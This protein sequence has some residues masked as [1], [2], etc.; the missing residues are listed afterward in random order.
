MLAEDGQPADSVSAAQLLQH[1][2]ENREVFA[3]SFVGFRSRLTARLDGTAYRGTCEFR[4]PDSLQ[5]AIP[6]GSVPESVTRTVR[7]MLMHRVPS[8][9]TSV[10]A[11]AYG[12]LD[13]HPLGR[14]IVL[15]DAYRSVYRIRDRRILQVD[16]RLSEFRRVL[17]VLE[18]ETAD[19]GRYLPRHVFA[20]VL[21]NDS[22]AMR[23]AWTYVNRFQRIG[24]NYLPLSRHVVRSSEDRISSLLIECDE[25][26]V[27]TVEDR[28]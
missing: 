1:A 9:R 6:D 4:V 25:I 12:E 8:T 16:R 11:A 2:R 18:T 19:T 22:G 15:A 17:T 21:D 3:A 14:Q 24:G 10:A 27:I 5:I 26:E 20:L 28:S 23:E 7:S 13:E